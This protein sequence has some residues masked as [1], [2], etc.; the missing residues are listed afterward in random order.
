MQH[1]QGRARRSFELQRVCSGQVSVTT[2]GTEFRDARNVSAFVLPTRQNLLCIIQN[3]KIP[4]PQVN[5]CRW[6]SFTTSSKSGLSFPA[7]TVAIFKF[8]EWVD[9]QPRPT[10]FTPSETG[11]LTG[12]TRLGLEAMAARKWTVQRTETSAR[13]TLS[14]QVFPRPLCTVPRRRSRLRRLRTSCA[15]LPTTRQSISRL[16]SSIVAHLVHPL[17]SHLTPLY[18]KP[19]RELLSPRSLIV[20]RGKTSRQRP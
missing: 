19:V 17:C 13:N 4:L 15:K 18:I 14:S 2:F 3:L 12:D 7:T 6:I 10:S 8:T 5:F 9:R 16:C 20:Q 1:M 11:H